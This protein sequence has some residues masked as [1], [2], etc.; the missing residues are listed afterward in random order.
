MS[1]LQSHQIRA[2]IDQLEYIVHELDA[3]RSTDPLAERLS[4]IGS[5]LCE[6]ADKSYVASL[7][8]PEV[9]E[10]LST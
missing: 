6:L 9:E 8:L 4:D 3:G 5:K 2:E 10:P 1:V 7:I